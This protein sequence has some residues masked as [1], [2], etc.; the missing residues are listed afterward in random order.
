MSSPYRPAPGDGDL[1]RD[2]NELSRH[3]NA[4][5]LLLQKAGTAETETVRRAYLEEVAGHLGELKTAVEEASET[6]ARVMVHDP[7]ISER[8]LAHLLRVSTTTV[9]K[10][11]RKTILEP[12]TGD[13][14]EAF[15]AVIPHKRV[16]QDD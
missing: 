8:R 9:R 2:L 13:D 11:T 14:P 4:A 1:M 3:A 7:E 12:T 6:T 5:E 15:G 16:N 10:W